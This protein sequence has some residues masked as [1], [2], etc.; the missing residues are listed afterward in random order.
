MVRSYK[1]RHGA[2]S[3]M[4]GYSDKQ[5]EKAILEV[6]SGK[7]TAKAAADNGVPRTTLSDRV[8]GLSKKRHGGQL[9]L[10]D[11]DMA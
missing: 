6:K 10:S 1:K 4:T 9:F 11:V 2:A 3:Y 8:R 5:M 7:S